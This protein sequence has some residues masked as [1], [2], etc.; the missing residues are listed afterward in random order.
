MNRHRHFEAQCLLAS[1]GQLTDLEMHELQEHI[2]ACGDCAKRLKQICRVN[3]QLLGT[4]DIKRL[5]YEIP[6]GSLGRFA[7][8]VRCIGVP[9]LSRSARPQLHIDLALAAACAVMLVVAG[10]AIVTHARSA[11]DHSKYDEMS[12]HHDAPYQSASPLSSQSRRQDSSHRGLSQTRQSQFLAKSQGQIA[13]PIHSWKL[14][15]VGHQLPS[16]NASNDEVS[17]AIFNRD[18]SKVSELILTVPK[19][20]APLPEWFIKTDVTVLIRPAYFRFNLEESAICT[21]RED[22]DLNSNQNKFCFSPEVAFL[23][24]RDK[25][26]ITETAWASSIP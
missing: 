25:P 10:F 20:V 26:R 24:N 6:R 18:S 3:S 16:T 7:Q 22:Y 13:D 19:P 1:C 23:A 2:R 14:K 8:K 12:L 5:R 9:I 17:S 4:L 21:A 15:F 11:Q